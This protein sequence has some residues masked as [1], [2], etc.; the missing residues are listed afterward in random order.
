MKN[1]VKP[2]SVN[3]VQLKKNED[4]PDEII[5]IFNKLIVKNWDGN[6]AIIKQDA[7]IR[8]IELKL[9]KYNRRQI[10]ENN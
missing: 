10:F 3:E 6:S 9:I 7:V 1:K 5:E 8:E 4:I 2:I